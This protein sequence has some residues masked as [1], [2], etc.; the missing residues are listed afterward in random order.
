M[1]ERKPLVI[2]AGRVRELPAADS[3]PATP[4]TRTVAFTFDGGGSALTAGAKASV[5]MPVAC[6]I[7]AW[8]ILADQSG[9]VVFDVWKD[10]LANYPP[11]NADSLTNG[12][13]PAL[14][15]A[16]SGEDTDLADWTSVAVAAGDVLT[17]VVDS[18]STITWATLLLKVTL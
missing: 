3:L 18:C 13:E 11:T 9:S 4:Q 6:T 10:T 1:A 15:A 17:V 16:A 5:R 12:H 2:V 7:A 14:S 8:S